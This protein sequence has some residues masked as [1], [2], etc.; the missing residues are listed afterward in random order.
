MKFLG[1]L[2]VTFCAFFLVTSSLV[3][4]FGI[5]ICL[6]RGIEIDRPILY[7]ILGRA[8][9]AGYG[10]GISMG[11]IFMRWIPKKRLTY[12]VIYGSA[13][14]CTSFVIVA[15]VG[16]I[17]AFIYGAK[18]DKELLTFLL[19]ESLMAGAVTGAFCS[20]IGYVAVHRRIG[21]K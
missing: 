13:M 12:A 15:A 11:V 8:T 10:C 14:G 20:L 17:G 2:A 1:G 3:M 18:F 21:S 4:F 6:L 7:E 19:R 16:V 5:A 9:K